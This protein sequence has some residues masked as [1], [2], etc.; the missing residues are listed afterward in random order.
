[1]GDP[2]T[3]LTTVPFRPSG[4]TVVQIG[5][6]PGAAIAKTKPQM[7]FGATALVRRLP[8]GFNTERR[9]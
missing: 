7:A 5:F 2:G 4:P 1:M 6:Y 3:F 8:E 9:A